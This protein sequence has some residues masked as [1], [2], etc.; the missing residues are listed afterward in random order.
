MPKHQC[1]KVAEIATIKNEMKHLNKQIDEMMTALFG[2]GQ[3][4]IKTRIERM[5]G[6]ISALKWIGGGGGLAGIASLII[7]FIMFFKTMGG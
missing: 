2:N 3:P 6:G 1:D 4:G 5:I 7:S